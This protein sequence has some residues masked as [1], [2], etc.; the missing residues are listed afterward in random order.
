MNLKFWNKKSNI[1]NIESKSVQNALTGNISSI[2]SD[3]PSAT[4]L[5]STSVEV[6]NYTRGYSYACIQLISQSIG[7]LPYYLYRISQDNSKKYIGKS[8]KVQDR[9]ICKSFKTGDYKLEKIYEHPFIDLIEQN[10]NM[11]IVTFFSLISQYLLTIGNCYL[12]INREGNSIKSFKLLMSEYISVKYD[13][14]FDITEYQYQPLLGG[15]RMISYKPDQIIHIS[16]KEAGSMIVGRGKLETALLSVSISEETK[17]FTNSLLTNHMTPSSIVTVKN[18]MKD[19]IEATRIKD[20]FVEQFSGYNRGKSLI[21]FGDVDV[22]TIAQNMNEQQTIQLND[23]CRKEVCAVFGVPAD[24]LSTENSN[25]A[26]IMSA[27]EHF[28]KFTVFPLA[29]NICSQFSTFIAKEYDQS[30]MIN[31]DTLESIESD[32]LTQSQL[33]NS[34]LS[35][36]IIDKNEARN[37]LGLEPII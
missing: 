14:N 21:T 31:F 23:F 22:K 35:S 6:L 32:P 29:S 1:D 27:K 36:G 17:K 37:M 11:S 33:I 2:Y 26:T 34:Y 18:S 4:R 15:A 8:L 20:K 3:F 5:P 7:D 24:L 9:R 25:R 28:L 13:Q 19:E 12:L 10:S 16:S 30:F